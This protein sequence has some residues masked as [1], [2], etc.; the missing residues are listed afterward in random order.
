M[1][2]WR[3]GRDQGSVAVELVAISPVL[4]VLALASLVFGRISAMNQEVTEAARAGAEAAAVQPSAAAARW[5]G[6]LNVVAALLQS[7]RTCGHAT[8]STDTGQFVPGGTV[9]V[10]VTC[11]VPLSDIG[12]PGVPGSTTVQASATAPIDPYRPVQ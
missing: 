3:N 9:T 11:Q 2:R 4:V 12:F 8:V 1:T 6:S 5:S 10:R 7:A